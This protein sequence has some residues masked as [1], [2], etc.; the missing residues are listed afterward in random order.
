MLDSKIMR[1]WLALF[2]LP[3][4]AAPSFACECGSPGHASRY[5]STADTVFVGKVLFTNDD[6]SGTDMQQTLV[7]FQVD[8]AFKGP[9]PETHDVWIDPGSFTGCYAEYR[10][11]ERYLVF[12]YGTRVRTDSSAVTF[13]QKKSRG[14]PK[15]VPPGVDPK[16]PP[17]AYL[18]PEC[19]GT[20]EAKDLSTQEIAY[21]RKWKETAAAKQKAPKSR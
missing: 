7:H 20:R 18:A 13:N 8:E 15:P 6:G 14:K 11:G 16:S 17:K 9:G 4:C 21:L 19:A 1:P 2:F 12:G 10:I 5:I 3:S